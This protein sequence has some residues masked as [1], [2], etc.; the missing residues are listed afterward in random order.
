MTN[1]YKRK[2]SF[3]STDNL[4]GQ[5]DLILR[6]R[7]ALL[8]TKLASERTLFAYIRTSLYLLTAGIGILEIKSV[9]HLKI[10]AYVSLLFSVLLFIAGLWKYYRLNKYLRSCISQ[11][12]FSDNS[13]T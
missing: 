8:R 12:P 4:P 6:D 7:L 13:I 11:N 10:I 3:N 5:K 9:E 2:N 1:M